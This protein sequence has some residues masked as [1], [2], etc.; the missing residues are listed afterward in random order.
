M[1]HDMCLINPPH[2]E[3][4][5]PHAQD[6]LGLLY[7]AAIVEQNG[8]RVKII[9]LSGAGRNPADWTLPPAGAYGITGTFLDIAM[10]NAVAEE[11]RRLYPLAPILVGG[12]VA[13][14]AEELH[15]NR[16]N[17]IVKG[18]AENAIMYLLDKIKHDSHVFHKAD[19]P[20]DLDDLPLPARHLWP[21][22]TG[23]DIF[24]EG[25]NYFGGGTTTI[26]TS[27][28]CPYKC[29]FCASPALV[30]RKIRMR[31][32]ASV[33]AEL[34]ACVRDF[35]IHQFRFSDEHFTAG[36]DHAI[37]VCRGIMRSRIL[38]HGD[39]IAWRASVG[40][41]PN[42][43][44]LFQMMRG[45]GCR[46]ISFGVES[47]DP[48]VLDMICRKGGPADA[49]AAIQNARAAGMKTKA[50]MMVGTPGETKETM[51]H[52]LRF[53]RTGQFDAVAITIFTPIPGSDIWE[54]PGKYKCEI[55]AGAIR[56]LCLYD[57]SGR[58]RIEPTIDVEGIS[59]EGLS[60]QMQAVVTAAECINKIG[61]G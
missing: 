29:G 6:A 43:L 16:I 19:A 55:R 48:A 47:A 57:K 51:I 24:I 49:K 60:E 7:L 23:G 45:G 25:H 34:E 18:E 31:S 9:N 21:G 32:A 5:N 2:P 17:C 38:E 61:R 22:S 41:R 35:G 46:E 40:V 39:A 13:L 30:S 20:P 11:V 33:V 3:L 10:V 27:R 59:F 8:Q 4:V 37:E 42:D 44:D 53:I 26:L 56:G 28:G 54:N 14:S 36:R 52:N 12:P 15:R 1:M 50:L 58:R